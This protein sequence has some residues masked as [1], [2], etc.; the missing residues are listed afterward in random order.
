MKKTQRARVVTFREGED[1]YFFWAYCH[2]KGSL[3]IEVAMTAYEEAGNNKDTLL[4]NLG[5][6]IYE[7]GLVNFTLRFSP[8]VPNIKSVKGVDT[9]IDNPDGKMTPGLNL[10]PK[11]PKKKSKK[12]K[13]K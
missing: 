8:Q 2:V 6:K 9:W 4:K 10:N 5:W 12:G 3:P 13:A 11:T 1:K 7:T